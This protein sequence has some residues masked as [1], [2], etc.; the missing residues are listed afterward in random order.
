M[1]AKTQLNQIEITSY[2]VSKGTIHLRFRLIVENNGV[3]IS[4]QNHRTS[5]HP[6]SDIDT[7]LGIVSDHI[8]RM[9]YPAIDVAE[10]E[11][12]K[13]Q[14]ALTWTPNVVSSYLSNFG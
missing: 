9:G 6:G 2:G 10:I 4:T 12:I 13:S 14:C 5:L 1:Q 7:Q 8:V 11:N 3:E